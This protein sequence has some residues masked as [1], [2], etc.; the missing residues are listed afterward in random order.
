MGLLRRVAV[1]LAGGAL[2]V[3]G[4]V[5]LILPGPGLLLIV[6]GL[7]VLASEYAW[8]RRLLGP[9]R[10]QAARGARLS[11][12]SPWH[13]GGSIVSGSALIAAGVAWMVLPDTLPFGGI[14]TGISLVVSGLIVV[15]LIAYSF[16]TYRQR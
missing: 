13:I 1:T 2:C 7:V 4:G 3:I 11:V 14:G 6:A 5:L 10:E 9:A 12:S 15:G 8:A 16:R